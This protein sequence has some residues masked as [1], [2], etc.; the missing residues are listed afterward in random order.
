MPPVLRSNR[1]PT[2]QDA[3]LSIGGGSG[4]SSAPA[5]SALSA[6]ERLLQAA[7][8]AK[9]DYDAIQQPVIDQS[10]CSGSNPDGCIV[11]RGSRFH[12]HLMGDSN[13]EM[14]IPA[15][16][17]LATRFDFTLS[18]STRPG[19]P[20]QEGVIWGAHDQ[21]LIDQCVAARN[22]WYAHL[23]P[24]LHADVIVA[25]A[26]AVDVP[27]DPGSRPDAFFEPQD[28]SLDSRSLND[29]IAMSTKSSLDDLAA[30]GARVVMLE[31]LPYGNFDPTLCISGTMTMA[32]CSYQASTTPYPTEVIE[33]TE[34]NA[35][36]DVFDVDFDQIACPYLPTCVPYADG[37]LVFRNEFHLSNAW[38]LHHEDE[39][40][41]AI[42]ASHALDGLR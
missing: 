3:V 24:A 25:V 18:V 35:R 21:R 9:I 12:L 28:P 11:H 34:A 19:C 13:A 39:L 31:P 41:Q 17:D 40:W 16:D 4:G 15:F 26:V 42:E 6:L 30:T 14:L 38:I 27:R 20:W 5:G 33:P 23:L 32:K 22:D 8:P 7:P 37:E 29:V 2:V 1:R 36:D 10:K